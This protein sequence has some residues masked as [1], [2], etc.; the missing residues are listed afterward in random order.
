MYQT[1]NTPLE[2]SGRPTV[3]PFP[4]Q[5][6]NSSASLDLID[7][8]AL[9]GFGPTATSEITSISA[10]NIFQPIA[11]DA[12]PPQISSRADHPVPRLGIQQQQQRLQTNKF[13]SNFF[14]GD[15]TN[16]AWTHPYSVSWSAGKGLA[17]S[18]GLAV[19][20]IERSQT[21]FGAPT[22]SDA[23][24]ASY[25]ANFLDIQSL[26]LSATELGAGSV[27]TTDS[28]EAFSVNVNLLASP[29][30]TPIVTF[31]LVQG[32]G[33]VTG[34]YNSA[35]PLIESG[36]GISN[37]T[38]VGA[39]VN[40]A[41]IKY[42]ALLRDGFT[43]L[44]YIT[45]RNA[46]YQ[47]SAFTLVSNVSIQGP[48]GFGG[49]IQLAKIPA[50]SAD[51]E[52]VYDGSVGS[53]ATAADISGSIEG[54]TGSYSLSWSKQ[55]VADQPLLIFALPHHVDS[56]AYGS[57]GITDVQLQ[58][59]TKGMATAVRADTWTLVEPN[60]PIDM[61]FNPWTPD[62]GDISTLPLDVITTINAA[63]TAEL[64]QDVAE[65]TNM[66]SMY[67]DGKALAKYAAIVYVAHDLA[68]NETLAATGL[69]KLEAAF[70]LHVDNMQT[71]GLVYDSAWGG[72]VSIST[73]LSGNS[74]D[75]FGNTY[76]NV[77]HLQMSF[78][79]PS[80]GIVYNRRLLADFLPRTI[81]SI[82][83]TFCMPQ[84]S[85][86]ISDLRG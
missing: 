60:L 67:Y 8:S 78:T 64:A 26:I 57:S 37:L 16:P 69:E 10:G 4:S 74:G 27:L 84:Q 61:T 5:S 56:L 55:G 62:G 20:H 71:F 1:I 34:S 31:P 72:A 36:I 58:T 30:T 65:A 41:T 43:W 17:E 2:T 44:I 23:G 29:D 3:Q 7:T 32:M 86:G 54:T 38:Y 85:L 40:G 15:Q 53:Y 12:V 18:Y 35:T 42:R 24:E 39:V 77:R 66:D 48:S 25:F 46:A 75:D 21:A 6:V 11:T 47:E 45:P 70:G 68:H 14:L 63:A 83:G 59:T 80:S 76:Y 22:S 33:F 19:S 49:Y 28:L 50:G 81:I 51:A 79:L 82:M 9:N 13:Y 73:Y 52:S